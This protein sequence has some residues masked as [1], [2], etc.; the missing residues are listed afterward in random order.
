M[1]RNATII[2]LALALCALVGSMAL[3]KSKF[4][5]ISF[6]QD[7]LVNGTLVKKGDYQARFNE[8]NGELTILDGSHAVITTTV[9]EEMLAKKA[10]ATSFEIR[11]GDSGPMLTKIT[12]GGGRYALLISDNQS[13]EGQ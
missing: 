4:H 9:K 8:Q 11:A 5:R 2:A 10:P 6:E 1:K 12:F 3:A 7:M 13:A